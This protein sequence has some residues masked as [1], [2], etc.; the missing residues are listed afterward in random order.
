MI[1]VRLRAENLQNSKN[2]DS[3]VIDHV[4]PPQIRKGLQNLRY[5]IPKSFLYIR[6]YYTITKRET[7]QNPA[8]QMLNSGNISAFIHHPLRHHRHSNRSW[9]GFGRYRNS[10]SVRCRSSRSG[11]Y[12]T[13]W[14]PPSVILY[15][16]CRLFLCVKVAVLHK[17]QV[18][19]ITEAFPEAI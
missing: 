16:A 1:L 12:Q 19:G 14:S 2:P 18:T 13:R 11:E 7:Q 9:Q 3:A 17:I 4:F 8:F 10:Q 15:Q 5:A 6:F